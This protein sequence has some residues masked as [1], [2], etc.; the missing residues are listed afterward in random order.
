M[1]LAQTGTVWWKPLLLGWQ[2]KTALQ[3][4]TLWMASKEP[5]ALVSCAQKSES[6][7]GAPDWPTLD[8][9]L[10]P[11]SWEWVREWPSGSFTFLAFHQDPHKRRT[12]SQRRSA[13]QGLWPRVR[14]GQRVL[15][16]WKKVWTPS[17]NISEL[18]CQSARE[19]EGPL[20][21]CSQEFKWNKLQCHEI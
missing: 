13:T 10:E 15:D 14:S 6:W 1:V 18:C 16:V 9:M 5:W 7:L 12:K 2:Q 4:P 3:W 19:C 20:D 17:M 8:H 11:K 21:I